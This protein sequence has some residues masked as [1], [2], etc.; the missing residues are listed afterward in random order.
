M[1][2]TP[3]TAY[4]TLLPHARL[5]IRDAATRLNLV[6]GAAGAKPRV[7]FTMPNGSD[8]ALTFDPASRL[9]ATIEPTPTD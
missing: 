1:S 2:R 7:E 4:T 9:L 3:P 5:K 8:G 6:R